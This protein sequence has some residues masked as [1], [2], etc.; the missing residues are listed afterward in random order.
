MWHGSSCAVDFKFQTYQKSIKSTRARSKLHKVYQLCR[1][2]V[3]ALCRPSCSTW[4]FCA[5]RRCG[6]AHRLARREHRRCPPGC[7]AP[8]TAAE[9]LLQLS[10]TTP[11]SSLSDT[12]RPRLS[13]WE[14]ELGHAFKILEVPLHKPPQ[15]STT[16][17]WF[18]LLISK[19]CKLAS[20]L[21]Q[22]RNNN[23]KAWDDRCDDLARAAD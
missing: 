3:W 20:R 2:Q 8:E 6:C 1:Q 4:S 22:L 12:H 23:N 10:R 21:L 5:R 17:V 19:S 15:F 11:F 9:T 14:R 16:T 13:R 18:V 7:T